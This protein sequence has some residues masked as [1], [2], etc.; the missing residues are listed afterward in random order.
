MGE[1]YKAKDTRLD[2]T[3]AVKVLPSHLADNPDLKQ[4]FERE[5]RAVSSLNHPHICTLHDIGEQDGT[6]FLVMEYLEGE[7]LDGRLKKGALPLDQALSF[8][9]EISDALDKA[10]RQGVVHRD[11]KPGNIMLTKSGAKLL[12]FGLAKLRAD[13][14]AETSPLLSALPTEEKPLT[15][16]GSLLGTFQY[17]AP[18]QLEGEETDARTDIFAFGSVLYEMVTGKRAFEGK[19][20]ASL[21]SA[22]M[23]SE[24]R[25]TSELQPLAP[26]VLER[27]IRKC[28]AKEPENRW[29]SAKDLHDELKWITEGGSDVGVPPVARPT[30]RKVVAWGL[31]LVLA[32]VVTGI[33]VWSFTRSGPAAPPPV[34]R[35][36]I[37][38]P[39]GDRLTEAGR[40]RG[41]AISPD[42]K[43]I[44]YVAFRGADTPQLFL[45]SM[46]Q[47]EPTPIGGTEGARSPF[48]SPDGRWIGFLAGGELKKVSVASGS[49]PLTI[50]EAGLVGT[51][52]W[53]PDDTIYFTYSD[54]GAV[55]SGPLRVSASGGDPEPLKASGQPEWEARAITDVLPG[56]KAVLFVG[57][58][59][60]ITNLV[61]G[62]QSLETNEWRILLRG[63][64]PAKYV[65]SGHIVLGRPDSIQAVPFD[66]E[67]LELT[68]SPVPVLKV[69]LP[70]TEWHTSLSRNGSLVYI[71]AT[72]STSE[73]VPLLWVDR[74]G[75]AKPLTDTLRLHQI[76]RLSP[77]G[78]LL[79][80]NTRQEGLGIWVLDPA[81]DTMARLTFG[82]GANW[83]PLWSPDGERIYF[84]SNRADKNKLQ[85]FWKSA[86][87]SG[88]AEQL[89]TGVIRI[90]TSI[91]SD[92]KTL[93]FTHTVENRD[94]GKLLLEGDGEPEILLETPFDEHSGML[95][96]DDR[97]LAYVSNESGRDEVYVRTFPGSGGRTQVSTDGG[98]EPMW[99]RDGRELFYRNGYKMMAVSVSTDPELALGKPT[100]LFEKPY[101]TLRQIPNY[102]V[103]ADGRF[104]MVGIPPYE[105]TRLH[106][107]LNWP[108]E[109][110]RLVP[111]DN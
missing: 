57:W 63:G 29:Q 92:G 78:R 53:G 4:R 69:L 24:P 10:H 51:A 101:A 66:L 88:D 42:G 109:L 23:S 35:F 84:A 41:I 59:R 72:V 32:A 89:T 85:I 43:N 54:T 14:S 31:S 80:L 48:F 98:M 96:P 44:A 100:L 26:A 60:P 34:M 71:P 9:I 21:I 83:A 82:E 5:A 19:S 13:V 20:Q 62:I 18:E 79:A 87:G 74:R 75:E 49:S 105:A 95:S 97:W 103:A 58:T 106:I 45:R 28:L 104:V 8:S 17:M 108:E 68:G 99:S 16:E 107:V 55:I 94:I 93:I 64:G 102:D 61:T 76:P 3:V 56:G 46:D 6:D 12:D 7:T 110:K 65:S 39:Q 15:K 47:M 90:P 77:D 111:T 25:P 67:R 91:S 2:R 11:L 73:G 33:A 27:T 30:S 37:D 52:I 36:A 1:V 40:P 70:T 38:L 86:D 81:R 22:I 50:C